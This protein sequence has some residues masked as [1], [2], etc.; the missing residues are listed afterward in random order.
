M[1]KLIKQARG[2]KGIKTYF[3]TRPVHNKTFEYFFCLKEIYLLSLLRGYEN[4]T[5]LI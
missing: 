3:A 5:S 4:S 2:V 1:R